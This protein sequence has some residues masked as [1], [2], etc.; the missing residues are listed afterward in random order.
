MI[1]RLRVALVIFGLTAAALSPIGFSQD[2]FPLSTFPMFSKARPNVV[3][4]PRVI[5]LGEEGEKPV[6]PS[7]VASGEV[8]QAKVAIARA[9][10]SPAGAQKLCEAVAERLKAR[11]E[12]G[13][14]LVVHDTLAVP[15]Y[16][17]D[18]KP[19]KRTILAR[20]EP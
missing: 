20:C 10:S 7:V 9:V 12:A 15:S 2:S 16:L 17:E 1:H 3:E 19:T 18:G 13:S 4:M 5:A 6:P 11:G 14:L 8:L